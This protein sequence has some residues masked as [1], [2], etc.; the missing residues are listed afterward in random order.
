MK[1]L[2]V[3]DMHFRLDLP[4]AA[5]FEDGRK[6]EWEAV[7]TTIIEASKTCDA[8]VL[9]GDVLDKRHNHSSVLAELV[10]FLKELGDKDV[11]ILSGNHEK[12]EG[13]KTAL[14]FLRDVNSK[15]HV[16]T[17]PQPVRIGPVE[18][19]FHMYMLP[20]MTNA[21]LTVSTN[22]EGLASIMSGMDVFSWK[23]DILFHHH[24]MS[25]NSTLG[26]M[27]D[28]FN[29]I[30]LDTK[31][32]EQRFKKT[33]GGHIHEPQE[34]GTTMVAG[35]LFTASVGEH[36]K[37]VLILDTD[38]LATESIPLP[39]RPIHHV[40]FTKGVNLGSIPNNAIV[41]ATL[42][43]KTVG[44]D[45]AHEMLSRFDAHILVEDYPNER[46]KAHTNDSTD[47]SIDGLLKTYAQ[48][49]GI[50]EPEIMSAF[51]LIKE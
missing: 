30:I 11:H 1:I 16:Y 45:H 42:R 14:D 29:E 35:S 25:G 48:V 3:G 15:W 4:Y 46:V 39:V 13:S 24:A 31:E 33:I 17:T 20:Y 28:L 40:E 44:A 7:K 22:E 2:V 41:K 37:R 8:V 19:M 32:L 18:K 27:T 21:E 34:N 43:D 36:E 26:G 6:E 23:H 9:L 10:D 47:L 51:D 49:R 38:T 5:H 50:E 12:Y